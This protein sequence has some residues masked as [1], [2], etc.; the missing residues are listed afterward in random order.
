[1]ERGSTDKVL[2]PCYPLGLW[3]RPQ[4][5]CLCHPGL[6]LIRTDPVAIVARPGKP[7]RQNSPRL[8][9]TYPSGKVAG[10]KASESAAETAVMNK[11][12]P[13][14]RAGRGWTPGL[15]PRDWQTSAGTSAGFEQA[16]N[17]ALH[18]SLPSSS[19]PSSVRE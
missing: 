7:S 14:P 1:M 17:W 18:P 11:V 16:G 12:P 9:T 13:Q 15:C 2:L 8:L 3:R 19:R 5:G 6:R 4:Q 10:L